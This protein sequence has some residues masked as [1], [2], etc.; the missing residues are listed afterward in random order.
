[1]KISKYYILGFSLILLLSFLCNGQEK[2][3]KIEKRPAKNEPIE[4][5]S[6]KV[7][8]KNF[9]TE[10]QV[11]ADKDWLKNLKLNFKNISNKTIV[12]MEINLKIQPQGK[13]QYPI[14]L[15]LRF[16]QMP[17]SKSLE[18]SMNR[19]SAKLKV[20]KSGESVEL[21]LTPKIL[22][23]VK[24]FMS[25]NEIEDIENVM[26]VSDFIVFNDDTA[27]SKGH[28]MLRNPD[29]DKKWDVVNDSQKDVSRLQN[30]FFPDKTSKFINSLRENGAITYLSI[31]SVFFCKLFN[32]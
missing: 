8:N 21:S 28:K 5:I 7:G 1:M 23:S 20:L 18:S 19:D 24:Q 9:N 3:R 17:L 13:L 10:N 11:L 31:N 12:Y 16:G 27:W 29:D 4:L 6:S 14:W 2:I 32:A 30:R 22:D 15:P 25:E 26:V